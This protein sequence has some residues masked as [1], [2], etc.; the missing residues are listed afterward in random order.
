MT[1]RLQQGF[2]ALFA[3]TREVDYDFAARYLTPSQL[4][5]FKGM[6]QSEQLHSLQ[7]LRDILAESD[8]GVPD[9]LL[10]AALL[11][12]VGKSRYHMDVFRKTIPVLVHLISPK[13]WVRLGRGNERNPFL[14]PF[15][16]GLKHA[17]WG[18]ELLAET[19]ASERLLWLVRH[20]GDEPTQWR[21][22]PYYDLLYQLQ[23][24]DNA[25]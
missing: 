3:F 15:V 4:A 24:A 6:T 8:V 20:H 10:K 1:H 11:H 16:V 2:R 23:K 12:D 5:L 22:H 19:G 14:R 17:K 25:N 21:E 9:D 13:L 18:A 7:V